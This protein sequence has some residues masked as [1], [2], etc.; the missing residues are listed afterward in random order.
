VE[1]EKLITIGQYSQGAYAYIAKGKLESFGIK[2][3]LLDEN[4][5]SINWLYS[6]AIGGVK[7]QVKSS[8]VERARKILAEQEE[9]QP[10]EIKKKD[11]DIIYCPKCN[12]DEV[13]FEKLNK[14]PVFI[15]WLLLGF[16]IPFIQRKW[17]CYNCGHQ[18]I[19]KTFNKKIQPT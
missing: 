19:D 3:I 12:S 7:L 2:C 4:L 8:D 6:N 15:S 18:W 13:Y 16:P 1:P 11:K 10:E 5:I 9:T 14:K 17:K